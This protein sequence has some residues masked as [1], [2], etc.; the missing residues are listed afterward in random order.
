LKIFLARD[1]LTSFEKKQVLFSY[2]VDIID[3][4]DYHLDM[5]DD[6]DQYKAAIESN[7]DLEPLKS[8]YEKVLEKHS[9]DK[10]GEV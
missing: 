1:V 2:K 5:I 9:I 3:Y 8:L 4:Y 7:K 6:G 10:K